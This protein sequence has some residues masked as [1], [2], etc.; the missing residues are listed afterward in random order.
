MKKF[1]L[2]LLKDNDQSAHCSVAWGTISEV[3]SRQAT[4][5]IDKL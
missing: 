3:M 2:V 5:R 4:I 1:D